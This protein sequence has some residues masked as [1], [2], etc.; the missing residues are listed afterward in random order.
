[1]TVCKTP[2]TTS[3]TGGIP[4]AVYCVAK[5]LGMHRARVSWVQE[6]LPGILHALH[7]TCMTTLSPDD[8]GA[9][10]TCV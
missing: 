5:Y 4:R 10:K 3:L 8:V 9:F 7:Q 6:A 2:S 1:M